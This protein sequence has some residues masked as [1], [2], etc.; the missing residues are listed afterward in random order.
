[1]E[2]LRLRVLENKIATRIFGPKTD[3]IIGD[4]KKLH[5]KK[6]HKL[7][8]SPNII[9]MFKSRMVRWAG[10]GEGMK[11]ILARKLERKKPLGKIGL[12]MR[13]LLEWVLVK[14]YTCVDST[15]SEYT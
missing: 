13:M 7:Y 8:S 12:N 5:N 1:M 4:W 11:V 6:L 2:A 9:R 14:F 10:Q 15:G 3:G